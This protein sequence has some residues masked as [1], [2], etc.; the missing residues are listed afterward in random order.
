[1]LPHDEL[2]IPCARMASLDPAVRRAI[3]ADSPS[4]FAMTL[5]LL[6]RRVDTRL[7]VILLELRPV[8]I[9]EWLLENDAK[10]KTLLNPRLMLFYV[11]ANWP[12]RAAV[13]WL[14]KAEAREP[15]VLKSCVDP[16]GR[17][18]LWYF[19][20]NWGAYSEDLELARKDESAIVDT[21]LRHGCDPDAETV[22]G[23]SWRDIAAA[24]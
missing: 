24:R 16:L 9:L 12:G 22:W 11:C 1:V 13:K 6:G 4:R 2:G 8:R 20:Y 7:V 18:L 3:A 23:L 15:G 21:L 14:E 19:L 17:N 5:S 10:T